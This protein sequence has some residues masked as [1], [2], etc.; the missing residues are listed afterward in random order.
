MVPPAIVQQT[1]EQRWSHALSPAQQRARQP[2]SVC[3]GDRQQTPDRA[4]VAATLLL[5]GVADR[6]HARHDAIGLR[7]RFDQLAPEEG[8]DRQLQTLEQRSERGRATNRGNRLGQSATHPH[9]LVGIVQKVHQ[10]RN[11]GISIG[12]QRFARLV[13]EPTIA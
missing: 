11:D 12:D 1:L 10:R 7:H 9:L 8:I 3:S 13:L 5:D 6:W 2:K 4:Q